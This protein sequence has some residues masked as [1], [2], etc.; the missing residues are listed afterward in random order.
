[1][2]WT[3]NLIANG[4]WVVIISIDWLRLERPVCPCLKIRQHLLAN[5]YQSVRATAD[6]PSQ[7]AIVWRQVA[8]SQVTCGIAL[9]SKVVPQ[10]LSGN[11]ADTGTSCLSSSVEMC[12]SI[13]GFFF[14]PI[15]S[16]SSWRQGGCCPIF[17]LV[18]LRH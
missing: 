7:T 5:L 12:S 8:S 18:W 1:M 14:F 10:R 2:Q 6:S 9:P 16:S 15:S 11:L 17:I 3:C 13:S 4:W